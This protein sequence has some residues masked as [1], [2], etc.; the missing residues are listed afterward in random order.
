MPSLLLL[1]SRL[2]FHKETEK[3]TNINN[4]TTINNNNTTNINNNNTNIITNNTNTNTNTI[5]KGDYASVFSLLPHYQDLSIFSLTNH[6]MSTAVGAHCLAPLLLHQYNNKEKLNSTNN[7]SS[8]DV[9]I[10]MQEFELDLHRILFHHMCQTQTNVYG[11]YV[12]QETEQEKCDKKEEARVA[13]VE[14]RRLSE[15]IYPTC[16]LL[17]HSCKPNTIL[18][19]QGRFLVIR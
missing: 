1:C 8:A 16:S 5:W 9:I 15:A 12:Y 14:Q 2:L 13:R 10:N 4:N 11:T 18:N 19:Y 3:Q 17:N 6:F 7:S